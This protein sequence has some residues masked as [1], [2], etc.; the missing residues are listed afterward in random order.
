MLCGGATMQ[1][2]PGASVP[3][4]ERGRRLR[5]VR[6]ISDIHGLRSNG[7]CKC[8]KSEKCKAADLLDNRS[9]Q[10]LIRAP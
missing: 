8:G 7:S 1:I 4:A 6:P 3:N 10:Q 2:D 9:L 5:R